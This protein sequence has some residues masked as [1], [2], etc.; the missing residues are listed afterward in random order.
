MDNITR[1]TEKG[2]MNE[3]VGITQF[4]ILV[5]ENIKLV[6]II[7]EYH[8]QMYDCCS[9]TESIISN[10][11]YTSDRLTN[12]NK[13]MI[14]L[15]FGK[16]GPAGIGSACVTDMCKRGFDDTRIIG[17]DNRSGLL[18]DRN[19]QSLLYD[20]DRLHSIL[21]KSNKS[22]VQNF[23]MDKYIN[24]L[25]TDSIYHSVNR[26]LYTNES[27]GILSRYLEALKQQKI[28]VHSLL[29]SIPDDFMTNDK[30]VNYLIHEFRLVWAAVMDFNILTIIFKTT[31]SVNEYVCVLGDAHRDNLSNYLHVQNVSERM[32]DIKMSRCKCVKYDELFNITQTT[33]KKKKHDKKPTKRKN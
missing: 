14:L 33:D 31:T 22:S 17:I 5:D 20:D 9:D 10:S 13:A 11:R 2:L 25:N 8:N 1:E 15:E 18:K 3:V 12:N 26:Q 23:L 30:Y 32:S 4:K 16:E 19:D 28:R 24:P 29:G 27:F 21:I 7:G 6:T